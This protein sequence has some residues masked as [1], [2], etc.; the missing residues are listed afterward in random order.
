MTPHRRTGAF[1]VAA[2]TAASLGAACGIGADETPRSIRMETED[3]RL[4]LE[5]SREDRTDEIAATVY[6]VSPSGRLRPT[7]RRVEA[8]SDPSK[9]L[10]AALEVLVD[11]ST[12][13]EGSGGL[14]SVV[15]STTDVLAVSL[16]EGT[17]A[18]DLSSAFASIGGHQELLAVGQVVLTVTTFPGVRR[19][20]LRLDGRATD[21]PLP[22]GSLADGPVT[23]SDYATLLDAETAAGDGDG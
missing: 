21:L 17:A 1:V 12:S 3:G 4:P 7:T 8:S 16:E 6:L 23:L 20:V 10:A 14:R 11:G 19:L 22:D 18:V 15:P 9:V 5:P 13:W 2:V